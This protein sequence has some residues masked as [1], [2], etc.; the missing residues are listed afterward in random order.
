MLMG[1]LLLIQTKLLD[2]IIGFVKTG[3]MSLESNKDKAAA[4]LAGLPVCFEYSEVGGQ[5]FAKPN[6]QTTNAYLQHLR[7]LWDM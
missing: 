4:S 1:Y 2:I 7:Y 6:I 5:V 3:L